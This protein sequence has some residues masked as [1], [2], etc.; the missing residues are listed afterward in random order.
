MKDAEGFLS[1]L[2]VAEKGFYFLE[3][4]A[5]RDLKYMRGWDFR[6]KTS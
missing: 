6:N 2:L 1:E 5:G 3:A 4:D